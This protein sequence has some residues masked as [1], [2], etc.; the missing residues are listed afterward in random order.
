MKGES[1]DNWGLNEHRSPPTS[2][3]PVGDGCDLPYHSSALPQVGIAYDMLSHIS[4]RR[5]PDEQWADIFP[6]RKDQNYGIAWVNMLLVFHELPVQGGGM[7][8]SLFIKF[9]H[10]FFLSFYSCPTDTLD[11]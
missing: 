7:L 6:I 5:M 2:S 1:E 3:S 8:H 10:I 9:S 11:F 4:F